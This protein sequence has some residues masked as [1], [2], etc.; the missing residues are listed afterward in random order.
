ML[1]VE[2]ATSQG[3]QEADQKWTDKT[4]VPDVHTAFTI[5]FENYRKGRILSGV[6]LRC[7]LVLPVS[8]I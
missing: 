6:Q 5:L 7:Q 1:E 2:P 8:H 3:T 4:A